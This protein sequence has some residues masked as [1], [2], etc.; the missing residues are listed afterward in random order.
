MGK[1][2]SSIG[3]VLALVSLVL[4]GCDPILGQT[5]AEPSPRELRAKEVA[6]RNKKQFG[7]KGGVEGRVTFPDGRPA[8]GVFVSARFAMHQ[9]GAIGENEAITGADGRYSIRGLDEQDFF[10]QPLVDTLPIVA[11][12]PRRLSVKGIV[13]GIDFVVQEGPWLTI[14]LVEAETGAPIPDIPVVAPIYGSR[15]KTDALKT[16]ANGELKIQL[17]TTRA[18]ITIQPPGGG[19]DVV[20]APEYPFSREFVLTPATKTEWIV[21]AYRGGFYKEGT[22]RGRVVDE[23][24]RPV[25]GARVTF[26]RFDPQFATS[27][28]EGRFSF[29]A[30]RL[31]RLAES[32]QGRK[33]AIRA[34]KDGAFGEIYPTA[35]ETWSEM[36]VVLKRVTR[37]AFVGQVVGPEGRP[38]AGVPICYYEWMSNVGSLQP[39]NGGQTDADG[40]FA[41]ENLSSG[42]YYSLRFGGWPQGQGVRGFGELR[43]PRLGMAPLRLGEGERRDLGRIV[44]PRAD[45]TIAGMVVDRNGRPQSERLLVLVRGEHTN[46]SVSPGPDGRFKLEDVVRE[47]LTLYVFRGD[48]SGYRT[49]DGSE[50][51]VYKGAVRAGEV[52]LRI[53]VPGLGKGVSRAR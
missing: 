43:V 18:S 46:V 19:N 12:D 26:F 15:P 7:F 36:R 29:R 47:A 37:P 3:L 42:A 2:I 30:K 35:E 51:Q 20:E 45:A 40:R 48:G 5:S 10:V 39:Q 8:A 52:S 25:S 33:L 49:S 31:T 50:D 1:R 34:E 4:S 24:G 13:K 53:V 21:K 28:A 9:T 6:V 32:D 27:D 11:P 44:V 41:V 17:R 16:D 22:F 23:A 38:L 14:R